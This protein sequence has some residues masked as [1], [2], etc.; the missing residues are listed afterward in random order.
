MNYHRTKS[1]QNTSFC[2]GH[3][4]GRSKIRLLKDPS[5]SLN[6]FYDFLARCFHNGAEICMK[7]VSYFIHI[8]VIHMQICQ[9]KLVFLTK[10]WRN[11]NN[12]STFK[13]RPFDYLLL[14]WWTSAWQP[15]SNFICKYF[16][17]WQYS[18]SMLT[19]PL[20]CYWLKGKN[21]QVSMKW[22]SSLNRDL[23]HVKCK[24]T[25]FAPKCWKET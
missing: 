22:A 20:H 10:I 1:Y 17:Q 13:L 18:L 2:T 25:K 24:R 4:T 8:L 19:A 15:D 3:W 6:I 11:T 23:R 16:N 12:Q 9:N 5:N 14:F 21:S 7:F